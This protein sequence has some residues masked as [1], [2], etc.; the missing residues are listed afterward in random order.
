MFPDVTFLDTI[1]ESLTWNISLSSLTI[2]S[3]KYSLASA[4]P[5][6]GSTDLIF[7]SELY[8]QLDKDFFSDYCS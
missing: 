5:D 8:Q 2:D 4:V 1:D 6:S 7:P 3:K